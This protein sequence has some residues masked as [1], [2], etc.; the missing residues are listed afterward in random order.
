MSWCTLSFS[1]GAANEIEQGNNA[2]DGYSCHEAIP[3]AFHL[4]TLDGEMTSY[5]KRDGLV[6]LRRWPTLPSRMASSL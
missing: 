3:S 2:A 4:S 1:D 5:A 6:L